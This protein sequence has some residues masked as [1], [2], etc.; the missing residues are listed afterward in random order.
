M[1]H[2]EE[3]ELERAIVTRD[4]FNAWFADPSPRHPYLGL[5]IDEVVYDLNGLSID[6]CNNVAKMLEANVEFWKGELK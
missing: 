3:Q 6:V 1:K 5:I 2:F 4:A